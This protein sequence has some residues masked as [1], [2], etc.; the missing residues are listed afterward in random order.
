[1]L[2]K[3]DVV[4][5][6]RY[7][8]TPDEVFLDGPALR[9]YEI[10]FRRVHGETLEEIA[11]DYGLTREAIR[12]IVQ[13]TYGPGID[14]VLS[15]RKIER[16]KSSQVIHDEVKRYILAHK[17]IRISEILESFPELEPETIAEFKSDI[18]KF[19]DFEREAKSY[20]EQWSDQQI[21]DAIN[22]AG[23]YFFPLSRNDYEDLIKTGEITGPSGALIM[24]RFG[25]WALACSK[26]G[27]ESHKTNLTY[28]KKWSER[29]QSQFIVEFL[30]SEIEGSSMAFYETWKKKLN[31]HAPSSQLLRNTF[32][33]WLEVISTGLRL[34]REV[35]ENEVD[36]EKST[37]TIIEKAGPNDTRY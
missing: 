35:W 10:T 23:T 24:K 11:K 9:N 25:T 22:D 5:L 4:E 29:E 30:E 21:L 17:G 20:T 3:D 6:I 15:E 34:L 16:K 8:I 26:A 28:T 27:I 18:K 36:V 14:L 32:G 31:P 13:K 12:Q 19:V 1:V 2:E 7:E 37:E 33:G